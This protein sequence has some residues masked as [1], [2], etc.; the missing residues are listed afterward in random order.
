MV[1]L[2]RSAEAANAAAGPCTVAHVDLAKDSRSLA[3]TTRHPI[4]QNRNS[5]MTN[6]PKMRVER[7]ISAPIDVAIGQQER[8]VEV[9]PTSRQHRAR[10]HG[11][12]LLQEQRV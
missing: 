5:P 11:S 7:P 9:A 6:W 3:R 8:Q 4:F 12:A 1:Q 2:S 10:S